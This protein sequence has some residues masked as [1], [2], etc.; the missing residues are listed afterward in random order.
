MNFKNTLFYFVIISTS[1]SQAQNLYEI[2]TEYPVHNLQDKLLVIEDLAENF[3][4]KQILNDSLLDFIPGNQLPR[5]LKIGVTYWGKLQLVTID[6]LKGWNL[7]FED[8]MIG[9]P[10]WAKSNGKVDVYAYANNKLI[11]HK[12][13]G[14]EYPKRVRDVKENWVLNQIS[15][16]DLPINTK[17]TLVIKANGNQIG[18]PA[19]F[20]LSARSPEQSHYHQ[21]YGFNNSFNLIML[22]VTFIILL[23][24][25]LQY[26]YLKERVFLW[27]SVWLFFCTLTLAMSVG[28]IIGSITEF[29]FVLWALIANGVF[30]SFWFFGRSFI[31]SKQKFPKLDKV[32][33]GLALFL[34]AEI[35]ITAIYVAIF[36]PQ[37]YVT[38]VGIHYLVLIMYTV[39]SLIVSTIL[40]FKKDLFARY[41]GIGSFIGT[42]FLLVGTL[43]AM[44]VMRPIA[45]MIDPFAT[46]IFLQIVIY[47]FGIAYRRQVLNNKAL[48]E[49]LHVQQTNSEIQRIKDLDEIKTRFFANISHEFR[50]PLSL[51]SGPLNLAK[52]ASKNEGENISISSTTFNV[53]T[54]NANRLQN[55]IDQLLELSKIES[56]KIH[57]NLEQGGLIQFIKSITSS[58]ESM[59]ERENISL[60][61]SYPSEINGAFFDKDKLEKILS[62]L[63][64]NAFKYTAVGGAVTLTVEHS[65]SHY[66]IEISDTGKGM[67]K[68]E[69]KRI[70]ERFYRVEGSEKKG[71]GI[72]LA[73]TKEMVDLHNGQISVNSRKN[74]GTTFKVRLPYTL[75][76]LPQ[77]IA[78]VSPY[79]TVEY[80]ETTLEDILPDNNII[81]ASQNEQSS[82]NMS[83]VLVVEDNEDLRIHISEILKNQY[84]VLFAE[85]GM[86]GERMA[87]EHIPDIILSDIMMPKKDGYAMCHDLKLNQK[88]SHI[89]IIML[90]AKAGQDNKNEGLTQGA[91]AYLTKP[92]NGDELILRIKNLIDSRKKMWEHFKSLDLSIVD[93]L[94]VT[95][96]DDKFLL[97]VISVI[98]SNIDNEQLSVEDLSREVGFSRAQLHRKLK[99]ISNK[100]ANQLIIEIRLN[101]AK[102]MLERK[103]GS[104][105]EIAY[106]VGYSNLS[107]FTKSFKEKFGLL[108]SKI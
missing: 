21:L 82:Q 40:I 9:P 14:V 16:D 38:G 41:F 6:S 90:T 4:P 5:F 81:P 103:S 79:Q 18:Y 101:E 37:T 92:F 57:L 51:I 99:A 93:D 60:N 11:F 20:N 27:F 83:V 105:S 29:R 45:N 36:N 44:G 104:V 77:D 43:W 84:K 95:S 96:I 72:G 30:Y 23:Y 71:S 49:K 70:F 22:G 15:L 28:M 47:S 64:T 31:D 3:S 74:E 19:Y 78:V 48:K 86:K 39:L 54:K 73:L 59:S 75:K 53:I 102:N 65:N 100:S 61:S 94:S 1:L 91:D 56:G 7:H 13:T 85:D 69:V 42:S 25:V 62:N 17:V 10:A 8:R 34:F 80:S 107:Y 58:F 35:L 32:M 55:L 68:E 52:K 67:T 26:F 88:T 106:S 63:I 97:K 50:T 46:G 76:S 12:K 24:H 98:K 33:L 2:N 66:S 108:P 89:P 87:L